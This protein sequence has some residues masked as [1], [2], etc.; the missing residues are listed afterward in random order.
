MNTTKKGTRISQI[1]GIIVGIAV[2]LLVQQ[3]FFKA[4]GLDQKLMQTASEINKKCP[5]MIDSETR[6][7]STVALPDSC[8]EYN[9]TLVNLERDT[10]DAEAFAR[11]MK[12]ILAN[13]IKTNP[14]M[15]MFREHQLTLS[16]TYKDRNG[17]FITKI[18]ITP[19]MYA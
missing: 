1:I 19:D 3:L 9:Y 10:I 18:T 14:N 16:Y 4:P 11:Y 7:D 17:V 5:F 8:F 6:I 12:P 2:M 13:H 15:K